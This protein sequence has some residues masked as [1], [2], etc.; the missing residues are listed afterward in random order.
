MRI[1][2]IFLFLVDVEN[3]SRL[4]VFVNQ[5]AYEGFFM[6]NLNVSRRHFLALSG[7]VIGTSVAGLP[8]LAGDRKLKDISIQLYTVR[9]HMKESVPDTLKAIAGMGYTEV[10][11]AGYFGHS[12]KEFKTMLADVGL[13][14]PSAHVS[15]SAFKEDMAATLDH[16]AEVGHNYITIPSISRDKR[17]TLD[18]Y[19]A[20]AEF[21]N[22]VGEEANKRGLRFNYHNHSF[23][24]EVIDGVVP[25]DLLLDEVEAKNMGMEMDIYW[26]INAG[27]DPFEYFDRN[28]GRFEMCHVKDMA[29]GKKMVAVGAGEIDYAKIFAASEKAGLKHFH[30][31]HD[32]PKDS[33]ASARSSIEYLKKLTF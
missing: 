31:E 5:L 8:V 6:N 4:H 13:K 16:A 32:K 2:D 20:T 27:R 3:T 28:P 25:Y 9:D 1:A 17:K 10:E 18:Q 29:P 15:M 23:E 22:K 11:T 21:F 24:F 7:A 30:V 33:F 12:A 19:K 14:T 26:V